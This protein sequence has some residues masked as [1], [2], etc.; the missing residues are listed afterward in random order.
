MNIALLIRT[1]LTGG[2]EKQCVILAEVLS[3]QYNVTL[4]V[5][6][7][8]QIN[9]EFKQRLK[10]AR[11]NIETLDA[12]TLFQRGIKFHKVLKNKNIDVIFSY[13]TSDNILAGVVGRL[14]TKAIVVGGIRN[15]Q[16][17][18][19]R[20]WLNKLMHSWFH[21]YTVF[22]NNSGYSDFLKKG[23]VKKK[24]L[25][26]SNC[27][28]KIPEK[29][30]ARGENAFVYILSVARYI[31]QKDFPSAFRIMKQLNELGDFK[32][33]YQV[34][35][36]GVLENYYRQIINEQDLSGIVE[37]VIKPDNVDEYYANA[38]IYLCTS[39]FEG[40]SNSILEAL[41]FNLPIVATNVGDNA[42]V[43]D[44]EING[45]VIEL[46]DDLGIINALSVLIK[47]KR[48]RDEFGENSKKYLTNYLSK[49]QFEKKYLS[50]INDLNSSEK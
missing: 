24:S 28:E 33:K 2:A 37:L 25:V 1:L 13:L 6:Y 43:V 39:L 49:R 17:D 38:D 22:N 30:I 18:K 48:K 26:I 36:Y 9:N 46:G 31:P 42:Y 40:T 5:Q 12:S 20:F 4:V 32:I 50:F 34:V 16:M 7:G 11:V 10:A 14:F 19:K 21:N 29:D 27:I 23:Y 3:E 41:S 47:D 35:G 44:N 15:C 8:K 45:Y